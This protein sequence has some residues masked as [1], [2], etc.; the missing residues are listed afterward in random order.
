MIDFFFNLKSGKLSFELDIAVNQE[1]HYD[2]VRF[3]VS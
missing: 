2:T 1:E 3:N